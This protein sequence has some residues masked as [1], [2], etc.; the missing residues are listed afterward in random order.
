MSEETTT[1]ASAPVSSPTPAPAGQ[2]DLP[3]EPKSSV[4]TTPNPTETGDVAGALPEQGKETAAPPKEKKVN[5][6][7]LPEFREYQSVM[8]RK[9]Q[10]LERRA[11]E[12]A[13]RERE[14]KMA[15][16]NDLEKQ[17]FLANEANERAAAL[18]QRIQYMQAVQQRDADIEALS[19]KTGAPRDMLAAAATY[20]EATELAVEWVAQNADKTVKEKVKAALDAQ[21][22]NQPDLGGGAPKTPLSPQEERIQVARNQRNAKD[23]VAAILAGED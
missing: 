10:E 15:R 1:S 21:K 2:S 20:I 19:K 11:N 13:A 16:M 9:Q 18:E 5:L 6:Y 4:A 17:R 8:T 7:E 12:L 3:A 14:T 22:A 23:F